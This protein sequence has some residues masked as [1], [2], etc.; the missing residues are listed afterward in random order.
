MRHSCWKSIQLSIYLIYL[1]NLSIYPCMY[2][3][4]HSYLRWY[5]YRLCCSPRACWDH[6]LPDSLLYTL[7]FSCGGICWQPTYSIGPYGG[8]AGCSC[9]MCFCGLIMW[10]SCDWTDCVLHMTEMMCV[11]G[12]QMLWLDWCWSCDWSQVLYHDELHDC[13]VVQPLSPLLSYPLITHTPHTHMLPLC[14]D[15][16]SSSCTHTNTHIH[17]PAWLKM[18]TWR[19]RDRSANRRP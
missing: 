19:R 2:R 8:W 17:R 6:L 13:H 10:V 5:C 11:C 14:C 4:G 9:V 1:S 3:K 15:I 7:P 12:D 18:R 16:K